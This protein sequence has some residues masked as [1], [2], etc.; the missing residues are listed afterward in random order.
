MIGRAR[1][2]GQ[3]AK[4][5]PFSSCGT[6]N[7]EIA[8]ACLEEVSYSRHSQKAYWTVIYRRRRPEQSDISLAILLVLRMMARRALLATIF[9]QIAVLAR[10]ESLAS[11][12]TS[13]APMLFHRAHY[14]SV[15]ATSCPF[16]RAAVGLL[17]NGS[18]AP[19]PAVDDGVAGCRRKLLSAGAQPG[20]WELKPK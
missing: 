10:H 14:C 20:N 3:W 1:Q 5:A 7:R 15:D 17:L 11:P 18:S 4:P 8:T 6:Q 2:Y 16:R 12:P 9:H 19:A 13:S